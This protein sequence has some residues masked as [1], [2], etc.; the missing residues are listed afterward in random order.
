MNQSRTIRLPVHILKD[1]Y[2]CQRTVRQLTQQFNHTPTPEKIA[3]HLDRP[4]GKIQ[5]LLELSEQIISSEQCSA[6]DPYISLFDLVADENSGF[7]ANLINDDLLSHIERCLD[8]LPKQQQE[9]ISYPFGLRSYPNCT[10]EQ[11][12]KALHLTRE[13]VRQIQLDVL[14]RLRMTLESQGLSRED[15]IDG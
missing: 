1:L 9:A 6:S 4:V 7:E 3:K 13:R 15:L 11:V 14:R 12:G 8:R 10:L 5:Y 2:A